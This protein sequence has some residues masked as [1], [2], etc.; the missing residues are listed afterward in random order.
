MDE[1][2]L[3]IYAGFLV[4]GA[5][6]CALVRLCLGPLVGRAMS[7]V[8][9]RGGCEL[10]K[11][12]GSLSA[13]WWGCVPNQMKDPSTGAYRYLDG[14]NLSTKYTECLPP[15]RVHIGPHYIHHP[16]IYQPRE[17]HSCLLSPQET[18]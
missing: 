11:S 8:V 1:A 3:E 2:G 7:S 6:V 17:S 16:S 9:S 5:D 4:R 10:R 18:L 13:N 14:A 15:A 12:L